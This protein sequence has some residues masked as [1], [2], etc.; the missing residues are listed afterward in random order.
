MET[1]LGELFCFT[2]FPCIILV[3]SREDY[4]QLWSDRL[5]VLFILH[6]FI[7]FIFFSN[8]GASKAV[9]PPAP[10]F[11]PQGLRK[12][13]IDDAQLSDLDRN[14]RNLEDTPSEMM[15]GPSNL[16]YIRRPSVKKKPRQG[17][18]I[19]VLPTVVEV[20]PGPSDCII[21]LPSVV[22]VKPVTANYID[23]SPL[24][25]EM[26]PGPCNYTKALPSVEEVRP[27]QNNYI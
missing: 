19:E 18:F 22:K 27:E 1:F 17:N 9:L 2:I 8:Q 5:Q 4:Y 25:V 20:K 23:P 14:R 16:S 26:K 3:K 21:T 13:M 12:T 10:W 15:P 24:V 6:V 7:T 11:H